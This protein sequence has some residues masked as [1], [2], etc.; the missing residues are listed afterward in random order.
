MSVI[1]ASSLRV[2]CIL[3]LLLCAHHFFRLWVPAKFL[4]AGWIIVALSSILPLGISL[5]WAPYDAAAS[6]LASPLGERLWH[7]SEV[8]EGLQQESLAVDGTSDIRASAATGA[9]PDPATQSVLSSPYLGIG[10]TAVTCVLLVARFAASRSSRKHLLCTGQPAAPILADTVGSCLAE[11]G[12]DRKIP[13]LV[14][15]AV[16]SPSIIGL[17]RPVL[18]FPACFEDKFSP[19]ELR[20]MTLHELGH[21]QRRDLFSQALIHLACSLHWFNPLFWLC[22]R[23]ARVD[24]ELACDQ[25][26]MRQSNRQEEGSYGNTLLKVIKTQLSAQL[27]TPIGLGIFNNKTD[28]KTRLIMIARNPPPTRVRSGLGLT[29]LL[30]IAFVSFTRGTSS[31]I[32]AE[33]KDPDAE[34]S[35]SALEQKRTNPRF[36]ATPAAVWVAPHSGESIMGLVAKETIDVS[37]TAESGQILYNGALPSGNIRYI[38]RRGQ[39]VVVTEHPEA[40]EIEISAKRFPLQDAQTKV[41]WKKVSVKAPAS[42]ELTPGNT[43]PGQRPQRVVPPAGFI[44]DEP[45]FI[46]VWN[47]KGERLY[48]GTVL[49]ETPV[50]IPRDGLLRVRADDNAKLR[51][52]VNGKRFPPPGEG[53]FMIVASKV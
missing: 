26:V 2:S 30:L 9:S 16:A 51:I 5:S 10:W 11:I 50:F 45:L 33:A 15:D 8:R 49:P 35:S 14:S 4:H 17:F 28:I 20:W 23:L 25:W 53:E 40:L 7:R 31:E 36:R 6:Y 27:P 12:I 21:L 42:T 34:N 48:R 38:P 41:F 13:V 46:S 39:L 3:L 1:L 19:S 24:C 22:A 32:Q 29:L 37:V 43:P 44:V 52:E 18:I 47:E